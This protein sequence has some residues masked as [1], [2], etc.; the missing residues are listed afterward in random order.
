MKTHANFYSKILITCI[1][2][3]FALELFAQ[4]N[5]TWKFQTDGVITSSPMVDQEDLIFGSDDMHLYCINA[6]NGTEKWKFN[7]F[8]KVRS[9]PLIADTTIYISSGNVLYAVDRISGT[10]EW[11][12]DPKNTIKIANIDPWDYH[13]S[14]P[15][16]NDDRIYYGAGDGNIY[17][18]NKIS[19]IKEFE[20]ATDDNTPIRSTPFVEDTVVYV[21][22][23]KGKM[24]AVNTVTAKL[25]WKRE[26][27]E[28][29]LYDNYGAIVSNIVADKDKILFG[30][31]NAGVVALDK[32]SGNIFW[33]YVDHLG[34]WIPG[35]PVIMDTL[36]F[37]G[38]SDNR[39]LLALD[40]ESGDLVWSTNADQNIFSKPILLENRI[41]FTSGNSGSMG[42]PNPQ[43]EGILHLID[44]ETGTVRNRF[45]AGDNIFS[46]PCMSNGL[47]YFGC[48]DNS[49]YAIDSSLFFRPMPFL[50]FKSSLLDLGEI[51]SLTSAY[52][53]IEN[54]GEAADTLEISFNLSDDI[55]SAAATVSPGELIL[56]PG[57]IRELTIQIDPQYFSNGTHYERM[58]I[59]SKQI[60]WKDLGRRIKF[61]IDIA[62]LLTETS[63]NK[64]KMYTDYINGL[65]HIEE[66]NEVS[67]LRIFDMKGGLIMQKKLFDPDTSVDISHLDS[68]MYI[69][70]LMGQKQHASRKIFIPRGR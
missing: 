62:S 3:I 16:Q 45:L 2:S 19:G 70:H 65:L 56:A 26:T 5:A 37:I 35:T 50:D 49:I 20:F 4:D 27:I 68:G 33:S 58:V 24:Y 60:K 51:E 13:R 44:N 18:I 29:I 40:I 10:E 8:S 59:S 53:N 61:K 14:S 25:I 69:C 52:M 64:V 67:V 54:T 48:F 46:S 34:S 66:M 55:N 9:T 21:G 15:V 41:I 42:S 57:E 28:S 63:S 1:L 38:G 23:W 39:S 31:R 22:D 36:V 12:F 32:I 47:I 7:T 43:T 11:N 17:G 30:S 6:I